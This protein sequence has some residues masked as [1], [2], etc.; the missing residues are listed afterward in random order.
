MFPKCGMN[1]GNRMTA[2]GVGMAICDG[3]LIP[4]EVSVYG[5]LYSIKWKCTKCGRSA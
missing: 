5:T 4:Y 2:E 1:Q 3:S